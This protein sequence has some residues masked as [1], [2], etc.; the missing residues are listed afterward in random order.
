MVRIAFFQNTESFIIIKPP[1]KKRSKL[2]S[3][4]KDKNFCYRVLR[5]SKTW[6]IIFFPESA[7]VAETF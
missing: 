5:F 2:A 4:L 7:A 3:L 6:K 1:L